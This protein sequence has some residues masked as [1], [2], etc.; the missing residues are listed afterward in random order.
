MLSVPAEPFDEIATTR[1]RWTGGPSR[2][3]YA[4]SWSCMRLWFHKELCCQRKLV[5]QVIQST[6]LLCE[7]IFGCTL[8]VFL[9]VAW[10]VVLER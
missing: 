1:H 4:M 9:F 2:V 3:A 8:I 7:L 5:M 10:H 6:L